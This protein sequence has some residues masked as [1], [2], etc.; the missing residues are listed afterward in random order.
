VNYS[1]SNE[2]ERNSVK[3]NEWPWLGLTVIKAFIINL[4]NLTK[5][6]LFICKEYHISPSEIDKMQFW[7]YEWYTDEIK[8]ITKA[9]EKEQ[10]RQEKE[11]ASL[12]SSMNPSNMMRNVSQS[13]PSM[14]K[15]PTI[16][17]PKL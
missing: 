6:K 12:Q 15:M 13:M 10:K 16:Q 14:P 5:N 3:S 1:I 7:E 17:M 8:E 9:Q 4:R 11:H 2:L